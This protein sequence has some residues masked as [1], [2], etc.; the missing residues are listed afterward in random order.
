MKQLLFIILLCWCYSTVYPQI[1]YSVECQVGNNLEEIGIGTRRVAQ[2]SLGNTFMLAIRNGLEIPPIT[3]DKLEVILLSL[4]AWGNPQTG[5]A[6]GADLMGDIVTPLG[7][8]VKGTTHAF[9]VRTPVSLDTVQGHLFVLNFE[10]G[11]FWCRKSNERDIFST[12]LCLS[13]ESVYYFQNDTFPEIGFLPKFIGINRAATFDGSI[14]W[15]KKYYV[16]SLPNNQTWTLLMDADINETLS[17]V[18]RTTDSNDNGY[19][20][21]LKVDSNGAVLQSIGFTT[22]V[23]YRPF[24]QAFDSEGNLIMWGRCTEGP[25]EDLGF[26]MKLDPNLNVIW[27]KIIYLDFFTYRF[28]EIDIFPDNSLFFSFSTIGDFP[29]VTGKIS[30]EGEL[31]YQGGY[32]LFDPVIFVGSDFSVM[33]TSSRKFLPDGTKED[34]LVIVKADSLGNVA[35]CPSFDACVELIDFEV[36]TFPLEWTVEDTIRSRCTR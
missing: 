36:E 13:G 27:E 16:D 26:V 11:T 15:S 30:S 31:I 1:T 2:D 9:Q 24:G 10:E 14:N 7:Y 4:D 34:G 35:G 20:F 6:L 17:I 12:P 19:Y 33:I 22:G 3:D 5:Y 28:L 21:V 29:I 25:F 32:A 23:Q 18:G 8:E